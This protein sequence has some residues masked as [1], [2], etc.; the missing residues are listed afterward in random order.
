VLHA[1]MAVNLDPQIH[2]LSPLRLLRSFW[3]QRC[4]ERAQNL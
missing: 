3:S 4:T 1:A 2:R